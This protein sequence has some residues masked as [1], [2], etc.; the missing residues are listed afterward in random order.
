MVVADLRDDVARAAVVDLGTVD[1]KS[2]AVSVSHW[3][4]ATDAGSRRAWYFPCFMR[5]SLPRTSRFRWSRCFSISRSPSPPSEHLAIADRPL[6]RGRPD[7]PRFIGDCDGCRCPRGGTQPV[8]EQL[9]ELS[10]RIQPH[11]V[12]VGSFGTPARAGDAPCGSDP[13]V[14]RP[15][16]LSLAL[17]AWCAYLV[18]RRYAHR[19]RRPRSGAAQ[20]V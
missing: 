15:H 2:P 3:R 6:D 12:H 5:R 16:P 18:F 17:S 14:Q 13:L 19:K 1:L 4:H 10:R 8:A 20:R 11:A 7:P 9:L